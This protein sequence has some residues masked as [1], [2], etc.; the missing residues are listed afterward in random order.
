[1]ELKVAGLDEH[2]VI[3][4]RRG[5]D[6]S[7]FYGSDPILQFNAAN[8]LR[9]AYR[10]GRLVKAERGKLIELERRRTGTEVQLVRRELEEEETRKFLAEERVWLEELRGKLDAKAF[11]V[12]GCVPQDADVVGRARIWLA[13]LGS[14]INIAK[15]PNVGGA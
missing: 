14:E 8:E 5:G 11:E 2:L 15:R 7:I 3:G 10:P 13:G 4:F 9:R 6:V 12:V 1:V